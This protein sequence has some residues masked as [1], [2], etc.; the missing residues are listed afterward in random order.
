MH[1]CACVCACVCVCA[2]ACVC[3]SVCI[4]VW[5]CRHVFLSLKQLAGNS[6]RKYTYSYAYYY[7]SVKSKYL[8]YVEVEKFT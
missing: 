5:Q 4:C 3:V 1:V 6:Y 7:A 2:C 8:I